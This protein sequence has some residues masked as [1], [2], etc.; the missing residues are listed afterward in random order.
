MGGKDEGGWVLPG[1][2][3]SLGSQV[4][5]GFSASSLTEARQ[6]SAIYMLGASD[7]SVYVAELPGVP[8]S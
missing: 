2:S 4:S 7:Q 8:V 5:R 6:S 3:F 1:P